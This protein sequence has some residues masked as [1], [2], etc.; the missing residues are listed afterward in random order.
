VGLH[1]MIALQGTWPSHSR[2]LLQASNT[3]FV[4]AIYLV[5]YNYAPVGF[6]FCEGQLLPIQQNTA[7]FSLLGTTFGGDGISTFRLPDLRGAVPVGVGG[8]GLQAWNLGQRGPELVTTD[9]LTYLG[10]Q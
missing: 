8:S 10:P 9:T 4:G 7:L 3:A 2:R 6:A 5:P 1:Y